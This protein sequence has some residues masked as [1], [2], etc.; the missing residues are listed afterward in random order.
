MTADSIQF[1]V[2]L[3]ECEADLLAAQR[4]RYRVFVEELGGDGPFLVLDDADIDL[5]VAGV[6]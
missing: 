5:A 2:R 1:Q 6:K 4:L 3:A